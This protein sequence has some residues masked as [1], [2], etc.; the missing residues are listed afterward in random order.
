M[1]TVYA[2]LVLFVNIPRAQGTGDK[3]AAR[4]TIFRDRVIH[5][6]P[7]DP[8]KFD[9]DSV[10]ASDNGRV[11]RRRVQLPV[12]DGP[13]KVTAHLVVKPIPLDEM[14]VADKWD[15]AGNIRLETDNGPD[16]ELVKFITAYGGRTDH[17]VDI[18]DLARILRGERTIVASI[19]TWVSPAWRVDFDLE[20]VSAA[21]EFVNADW[22][23]SVLYEPAFDYEHMGDDGVAVDVDVPSGLKRVE[24]EYLVSGHCTDGRG[25]DEFVPKDNVIVVDGTVVYRFRP[26]RDDCEQFRAVNPY[27]KKWSDGY[28]SSDFSRSGWCPGD[29]VQPL[30]LDLSD[31]LTPG[32]HRIRFV[33]ENIRPRDDSGQGYWR[34]SSRLLG[35]TRPGTYPID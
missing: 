1:A 8:G 7:D 9:S 4:V 13:V 35:W 27:C 26:W 29:V 23:A 6:N 22:V 33:I 16:I 19:D 32:R 5:F 21:P 24:L 20:Y 14:T 3:S 18:S 15:R 2:L 30:R 28:W 34:V 31:H 12:W 11:I 17:E 10:Q 25:A